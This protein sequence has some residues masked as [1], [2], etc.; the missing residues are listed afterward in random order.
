MLGRKGTTRSNQRCFG[1]L[2]NKKQITRQRT[3]PTARFSLFSFRFAPFWRLLCHHGGVS[4]ASGLQASAAKATGGPQ[5]PCGSQRKRGKRPNKQRYKSGGAGHSTVGACDLTDDG[6]GVWGKT[7]KKLKVLHIGG[8]QR[9]LGLLI[10]V[11]HA[12]CAVDQRCWQRI[13]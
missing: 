10:L 3:I 13:F 2:G 4:F 5:L 7:R 9:A 11:V 12:D 1:S 8:V 6:Q